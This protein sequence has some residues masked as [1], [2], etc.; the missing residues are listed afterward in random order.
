MSQ[1]GLGRL[2]KKLDTTEDN[3]IE[4]QNKLRKELEITIKSTLD[5]ENID[6]TLFFFTLDSDKGL[7]DIEEMREL[8]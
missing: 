4:K 3:K 7:V 6:P 1:L 8:T 2:A 5:S